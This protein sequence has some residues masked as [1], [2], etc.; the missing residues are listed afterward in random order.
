MR[1][2]KDDIWA[3][4]MILLECAELNNQSICY[5]NENSKINW[6]ILEQRIEKVEKNYSKDIADIMRNMLSRSRNKR[7]SWSEISSAM[8][9]IRADGKLGM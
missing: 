7:K 1:S 3:F 4:G 8:E 5:R 6:N 2:Y 9:M